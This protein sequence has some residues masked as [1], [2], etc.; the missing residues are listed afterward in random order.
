MR[1][2][3]FTGPD[4]G[5]RNGSE[6]LEHYL[7]IDL[8]RLLYWLRAK[9]GWIVGA[10]VLGVVLA[11]GYVAVA[12]PRYTVTSELLIDPTGLQ[13]VADDLYGRT[14]QRDTQLLNVDGKLQ[15][16]LSRNVLTRVVRRLDLVNDEEFLP[17]PSPF[18]LSRLLP[19]DGPAVDPTVLAVEALRTRT[20]ARRD[21]RSFVITLSVWTRSAEKSVR[22]SEAIIDEFRAELIA[23]DAEGA[24]RTA[25]ALASRLAELRASVNEAEEAVETFRREQGLR[26][27]NG[28][29][30]S[31]RSMS[32]V[33]VQLREARE[34]L[35]AA[36]S[37]YRQ[38]TA[39]GSDSIAMQS[40]T[41][42]ALRTQ[43]ATLKQQS[44]AQSMTYGPRHPRRLAVESELTSLQREIDMEVA[45]LTRA[46]SS[47]YE[48][49][50]SVVE[51]LER[52]SSAVS[53]DVFSENEAQI[54][55]REL[56]RDAA[57]KSAIYET[58]LAR[59]RVAAER[60]E[61]DSTNIRVIS[62]P[63]MPKA[64]SWPPSITQAAA[65]GGAAGLTLGALGVLGFGVVSDIRGGPRYPAPASDRAP[66]RPAAPRRQ[67]TDR[68]AEAGFRY[69]PAAPRM[70]AGGGSML[71]Y[72]PGAGSGR[73]RRGRDA[74]RPEAPG[75]SLSERVQRFI[76]KLRRAW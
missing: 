50:R 66:A 59:A 20:V 21:E 4:G 58:F 43:Y 30:V 47:E 44:D 75:R 63:A 65:F 33:D 45:R 38:L 51:A 23:A 34:R 68:P 2:H 24:S 12:K 22:I 74:P 55:L 16:L 73:P 49:A 5:G 35:I 72:A 54:R 56:S 52:E 41:L 57:A 61:L 19:G 10:A 26:T 48:Q 6:S 42:S 31:S 27:A 15:T 7:Q 67:P 76:G 1:S 71:A 36:E 62:P 70:A 53:T 11:V 32:Q 25:E 64:R 39:G 37:R 17:P 14:D 13:I 29:L 3:Q 9:A 40:S 60:Q 28:E 46:A 8:P 69:A 18:S